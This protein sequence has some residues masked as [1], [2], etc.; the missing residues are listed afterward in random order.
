[1]YAEVGQRKKAVEILFQ[2]L[3]IGYT[4]E[5]RTVVLHAIL[6]ICDNSCQKEE[7]ARILTQVFEVIKGEYEHEY[8]YHDYI[9]VR[10]YDII[11]SEI[12]SKYMMFNCF[13]QALEVVEEIRHPDIHDRVLRDIV[14]RNIYV[15]DV[16]LDLL[17]KV[18]NKILERDKRNW[19][20]F[21]IV[22]K[23]TE[24]KRFDIALK[25]VKTMGNE[26]EKIKALI[27]IADKYAEAK[28]EPSQKEIALLSEIILEKYPIESFWK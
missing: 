4:V 2:A 20:L 16:P 22:Y 11:C 8:N 27:E 1:V 26:S 15:N 17:L 5:K 9:I 14:L 19:A 6:D 18:A 23:S 25:A 28:Q 7:A 21:R 12:A 10:Y 13:E 3:E 24:V